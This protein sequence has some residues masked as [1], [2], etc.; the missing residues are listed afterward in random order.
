MANLL[1]TGA[2]GA[3]SQVDQYTVGGTIGTETFSLT[4]SQSVVRYTAQG[5]DTATIVRDALVSAWNAAT[6][7]E[8]LG[9]TASAGT[10]TGVLN[11]TADTAGVPF[12]TTGTATGAA[13]LTKS[14][15]G[16][17]SIAN[18]G[19]NVWGQL[20]N[21]VNA[22]TGAVP[23][24]IAIGDNIYIQGSVPSILWNLNAVSVALGTVYIDQDFGPSQIGLP[25]R[26]AN[27]YDEYLSTG[28]YLQID[29]NLIIG[30]GIGTG[31]PLAKIDLR[32]KTSADIQIL[33]T[34]APILLG[35]RALQ[36][37]N[38][39][40]GSTIDMR[41]GSCDV[42]R[43]GGDTATL[44]AA[45]NISGGDLKI[46]E[47]ATISGGTHTISGGRLEIEPQHGGTVRGRGGSVVFLRPSNVATLDL[48]GPCQ[49][50]YRATGALGSLAMNDPGAVLDVSGNQFGFT[51]SAISSFT[52]GQIINPGNAILSPPAGFPTGSSI[53]VR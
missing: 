47:G 53:V 46:W 20:D 17:G 11:L 26:N 7:P 51:L 30:R 39:G 40:A 23:G 4:I 19:P 34:G 49:V 31:C 3:V 10:G 8:T 33:N 38:F 15:V 52:A 36:L 44:S 42:C 48:P 22:A 21:Y 5:G 12:E 43:L 41:G 14:S 28:T 29:A 18:E 25:E 27:G 6:F 24:S 35:Q 9:I 2:Q 45:V 50:D 1:W 37:R 13:T 32:A 16:S